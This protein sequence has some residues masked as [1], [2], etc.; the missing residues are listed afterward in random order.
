MTAVDL[1]LPMPGSPTA[2][3]S[4]KDSDANLVGSYATEGILEAVRTRIGWLSVF[5]IG[6]MLA[7]FVVESFED[8]LKREVE[9]SY[10]VPLLIGHGGNTGSQAVSSVIRALALKQVRPRDVIMVAIKESSTGMLMGIAL[11][12][13]IYLLSAV[14]SG[15]SQSVGVVVAIALPLV[16]LWSNLLGALLPL[17][18]A[19]FGTNPA[20]TAAPLMTTIVDS[21][22][23]VIYFVIAR[24][25]LGTIGAD[26]A[27]HVPAVA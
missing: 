27:V 5:F 9:L 18:S 6:L 1:D 4:G 12:L 19:A 15:M 26:K 7:A 25:V 21:T 23:L 8:V 11:G 3:S 17:L 20:V 16:S 2:G 22:G 24:M 14:W 10:F 13:L